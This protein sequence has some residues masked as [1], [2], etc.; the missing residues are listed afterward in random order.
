MVCYCARH[1]CVASQLGPMFNCWW[2]LYP[3]SIRSNKLTPHHTTL[4]RRCGGGGE[5]RCSAVEEQR[6]TK[7]CCWKW[8]KPQARCKRSQAHPKQGHTIMKRVLCL[9][10]PNW[11]VQRLAVAQPELEKQGIVLHAHDPRRGQRVKYCCD[12]AWSQG[13]RPGMS[14]AEATGVK[15]DDRRLKTEDRR[16]KTEDRR[17]KTDDRR[18]KTDDRSRRPKATDPQTHGPTDPRT[19]RPTDPQTH[20]PTDPHNCTSPHTIHSWIGRRWKI[21]PPGASNSAH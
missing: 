6:Q 19:H 1:V 20:G 10:L 18:P 17:P 4:P 13:I 3:A 5:L 14:L 2:S 12:I 7:R 15:T 8:T 16:P 9:W 11:P 21:W